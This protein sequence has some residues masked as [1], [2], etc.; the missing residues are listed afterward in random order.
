MTRTR[1]MLTVCALAAGLVLALACGGLGGSSAGASSSSSEPLQVGVQ[2]KDTTAS[3][4]PASTAAPKT[5]EFGQ[6]STWSKEKETYESDGHKVIHYVLSGPGASVQ[7]VLHPPGVAPPDPELEREVYRQSVQDAVGD[8]VT[9][10]TPVPDTRTLSGQEVTGAIQGMTIRAEDGV[11][12]GEHRS[13]VVQGPKTSCLVVVDVPDT[14]D[15][16]ADKDV[17]EV[18]TH[19]RVP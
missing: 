10:D 7:L 1:P 5:L 6:P 9:F 4:A 19:L 18:L 8:K 11:I 2:G 3:G 12:H 16:Q 17:S 15:P 13:W 14:S